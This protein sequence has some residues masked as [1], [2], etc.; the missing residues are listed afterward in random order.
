MESFNREASGVRDT[1][2]LHSVRIASPFRQVSGPLYATNGTGDIL[3]QNIVVTGN[4]VVQSNTRTFSAFHRTSQ[5]HWNNNS[6]RRKEYL[7]MSGQLG[8][9]NDPCCTTCPAYLKVA[10]H[11][12][13]R[14]SNTFGQKFHNDHDGDFKGFTRKVFSF[15]SSCIHG[16]VN[17]HT[18]VVQQW[19]MILAT[20]CMVAVFLDPLFFFLFYVQKDLKCIAIDWKLNTTL[21]LFRSL[22]D[23]IYFLNILLQFRLAYISPESTMLGARDLVDHP[24]KIAQRYLRGYFFLDLFVIIP[25]PQIMMLFVVPNYLGSS[26]MNYTKNLLR[27]AILVQYIPKLL[28]FLPLLR[29]QSPTG[30][31]FST[32]WESFFIHLLVFMLSGH[33]VGANWYLF[34]LQRVNQCLRDACRNSNITGCIEFIDCGYRRLSNQTSHHWNNNVNATACFSSLPAGAFTFG[35]YANVAPLVIHKNYIKKYVYALFWGFQQICTLA[36]NQTPSSFEWE[37]LFVMSIIGLGL[38]HLAVLIGHLQSSSQGLVQRRVENKLRESAV[39]EWMSDCCLPEDLKWRVRQSETYNWAATRGVK[40]EMLM[41]NMSEDLQR[42]IRRHLF[43]FIKKVRIIALM[44]EPIFDAICE[45]LRRRVYTRGSNILCR[46]GLVEKIVFVLHGKLESIEEDGTRVCLF[47]EDACGEELLIWCLENSLVSTDDK[48]L[49]PEWRL[50]SSRTVT[51]L[52][53]VKAF[54]LRAV[55][56]EEIITRFTRFL[57]SPRTLAAIRYESPYWRSLGA[58]RIQAAWRDKKNRLRAA[59]QAN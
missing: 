21:V 23:F 22:N 44:D 35:I 5:H 28:G 58:N 9:C 1:G 19:K 12:N 15:Y 4:N 29:D 3:Q 14:I 50:L 41:E 49:P 32:V 46:G 45:R 24:K 7:L 37:V 38:F 39:E 54:S 18:K 48:K 31:I 52:T 34:G 25:I 17:P 57:Q 55:D 43:K 40:E 16:V 13:S 53:D 8:M 20:F 11:E 51:C 26:G 10:Q 56:L 33:V 27:A 59:S 47:N 6:D 2:P 42:D 36:G 30:F